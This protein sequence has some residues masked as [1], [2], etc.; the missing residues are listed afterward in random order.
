MVIH[1]RKPA[2]GPADPHIETA[3]IRQL[4]LLKRVHP[5][6]LASR[7]DLGHAWWRGSL[8]PLSLA[9]AFYVQAALRWKNSLT[10]RGRLW[11]AE[12]QVR[13]LAQLPVRVGSA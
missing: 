6:I 1:Q 7:P 8:P 13:E 5:A 4:N 10:Y 3:A 11:S 2:C 12:D 9:R